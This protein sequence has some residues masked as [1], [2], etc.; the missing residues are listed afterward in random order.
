MVEKVNVSRPRKTTKPKASAAAAESPRVARRE[1]R[2]ER[3]RA[4]IIDAA[5]RVIAR[6]GIAGATLEAVATEVGLTKAA[7]YYYYPS[8]DALFFELIYDAV[9]ANARSVHDAVEATV[10]GGDA[11]RA[12]I[13]E[14]VKLFAGR[15]DDFRLVFLMGQVTGP[16]AI[17]IGAEQLE[18]IRPLN[19]RIFGGTAKRV[20]DAGPRR[21]DVDPRMMAFLANVAAIGLLTFK[22]M[23]ES[24]GDP[25]RYSDEQL[26]EGLARIF[27]AAAEPR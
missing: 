4:E 23:V 26:M 6:E 13:V 7:L 3:S 15:L 19:D 20:A 18:K 14:T 12:I 2:R 5:R 27:E 8:K 25:L 1:L 9:E 24:V 22:G 21:A 16:Q 11:L 10:S 17:K